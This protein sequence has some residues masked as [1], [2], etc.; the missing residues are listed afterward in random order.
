MIM[1]IAKFN[2]RSWFQ[3]AKAT[4]LNRRKDRF[5]R[6]ASNPLR[7][8]PDFIIIG[9]QKGGTTSLYRYLSASRSV[10]AA[11]NKE[12]HYFDQNYS[13]G[14]GWYRANFPLMLSKMYHSS[15]NGHPCVSGEATPNYFFHP[16]APTR[17]ASLLPKVK[18]I[19]L[20]RNP[21]D[22]ALSHY[23]HHV[24][25]KRETLPFEE[26]LAAEPERL[27]GEALRIMEDES[28]DGFA[29]RTFS[30]LARGIYI[31]Q[32]KGWL[33]LFSREQMLILK[34]EDLFENPSA[35]INQTLAFLDLPPE[36][37]GRYSAFNAGSYTPMNP[38]TRQRLVEYF[39]PYNQQL[40]ERL[41]VNF[42]WD[43]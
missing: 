27:K 2:P 22:R 29:F 12:V 33:D 21:V 16:K 17:I 34:S 15:R 9:V 35:I 36:P 11:S 10:L 20:L 23:N 39:A 32:L 37:P 42:G 6:L 41:G 18:L 24:R 28:Y 14:T 38:A 25:S 30:Y 26:A 8:L 5:Y 1:S 31:D 19:L 43:A 40:Y 3:P 4:G 7:V 13:Q